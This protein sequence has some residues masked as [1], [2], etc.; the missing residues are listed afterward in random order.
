MNVICFIHVAQE[1]LFGW[2]AQPWALQQLAA[3]AGVVLPALGLAG[4]PLDAPLMSLS[5]GYKR[6]AALAVA[7]VR[8]PSVLLLDEPLAGL[9]WRAR[10]DIAS[11]S[12]RALHTRFRPPAHSLC[13]RKARHDMHLAVAVQG[14]RLDHLVHQTAQGLPHS[15]SHARLAPTVPLGSGS[16]LRHT[17]AAS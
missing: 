1:L 10:A 7:L 3:R 15:G 8:R 16:I 5:D 12:V 6:R 14:V 13:M 9:D 4:V 17:G 2:P 11:C